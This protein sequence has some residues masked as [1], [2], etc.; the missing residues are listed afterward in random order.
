MPRFDDY[1]EHEKE[2][3]ADHAQRCS[4]NSIFS[5]WYPDGTYIHMWNDHSKQRDREEKAERDQ[6]VWLNWKQQKKIEREEENYERNKQH[7][8]PWKNEYEELERNY[9]IA[10]NRRVDDENHRVDEEKRQKIAAAI[11]FLERNGIQTVKE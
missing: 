8:S 10:A 4:K 6:D 5:H 3:Y 11:Q 2:M 7:N 1:P 9:K